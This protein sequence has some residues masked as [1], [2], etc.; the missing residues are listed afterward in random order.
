MLK[1]TAYASETS[2]NELR[3]AAEPLV[4]QMHDEQTR[5]LLDLIDRAREL[6]VYHTD[7]WDD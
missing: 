6:S 2:W 7:L 4:H 5:E 1:N 3:R